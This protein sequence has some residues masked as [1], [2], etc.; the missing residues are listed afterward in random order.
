M[1]GKIV[2]CAGLLDPVVAALAPTDRAAAAAA[3][4]SKIFEEPEAVKLLSSLETSGKVLGELVVDNLGLI[5]GFIGVGLA[6]ADVGL[7]T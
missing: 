1:R 3:S 7:V 5:G 4:V 2:D 6:I